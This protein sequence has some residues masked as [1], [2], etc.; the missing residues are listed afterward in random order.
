GATLPFGMVQVGPDTTD[1]VKGYTWAFDHC[2][3]Y[4]ASDDWIEGFSHTHL[5]GTGLP[6]LGAIGVM[7]VAGSLDAWTPEMQLGSAFER[8]SEVAK[9]GHYAVTLAPSGI[10]AEVTATVRT[11]LHRYTSTG[12]PMTL[13]IDAGKVAP[14]ADLLDAEMVLEDV[15][16]AGVVLRGSVFSQGPFT[17]DGGGMRTWFAARVDG[18]PTGFGNTDRA[19]WLTFDGT[20]PVQLRVG[21]SFVSAEE[22]ANNLDVELADRGFDEVSAAARAVWKDTLDG[23]RVEGVTPDQRTV[24]ATSLYHVFLMPNVVSDVSGSYRGLD[25]EVHHADFEYYSG[26][27]LWDTY[28][29]LHPLLVLLAPDRQTDMV[30]SLVRMAEDG[31]YVPRW[32]LAGLYTNIMIGAPADVVFADTWLKGV[33]GFD[34]E[35]AFEAALRT[36]DGPVEEGHVYEGRV[37]VDDYLEL[38][39]VAVDRHAESVSRTLEMAISDAALANLAEA[40]GRTEDA[41]RFAERSLNYRNLWD[42][43]TRLFRP[44]NADGSWKTPFDPQAGPSPLGSDYTEGNPAQYRWLAPHDVPG[45]LELVGSPEEAVALLEPFFAEARVE[46]ETLPAFTEHDDLWWMNQQP[47]GYWHGN[48]PGLHASWL[49]GQ[50]GRPDL[51]RTWIHWIATALYRTDRAGIPGNDDAGT[52]AAWYVFAAMGIYPVAGS[53]RYWLGA[54]LFPR[55]EVDLPGSGTLIVEADTLEDGE[56]YGTVTMDGAPIEGT[57]LRH[58]DLEAGGVLRFG[59]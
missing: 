40:L 10:R 41:A 52:L 15:D 29:T 12:G 23:V 4:H 16:G 55:L 3:G 20:E 37:G 5:H 43:E 2:S 50:A 34:G 33:Q 11:G 8:A 58:A 9:P 59:R 47:S 54:P 14:L 38:G 46:Q 19:A 28:R 51:A 31:G 36:A 24:L 42:Q 21:I 22:A 17:R 25:T 13:V 26:F 57:V 32:P 35:A 39:Y 45:L 44:R 56:G 1:S 27:S 49:F 30:K 18:Q 48:E 6:G 53:D 7:P